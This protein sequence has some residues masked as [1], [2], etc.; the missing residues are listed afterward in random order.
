MPTFTAFICLIVV[1]LGVL[2]PNTYGASSPQ[3]H[4]N[5]PVIV[6]SIPP[7]A[8]ITRDLTGQHAHVSALIKGHASAHHF[9]LALSDQKMLQSADSVIW[10]G[11]T[12]EQFLVKSLAMR[13]NKQ[14]HTVSALSLIDTQAILD[15]QTLLD[16][17]K[18]HEH[19][20]KNSSAK[21]PKHTH[22]EHAAQNDPHIWTSPLLVAQLYKKLADE[23][24][25]RYPKLKQPI[26]HNLEVAL[27]TLQHTQNTIQQ[28]LNVAAK[29][30]H[31]YV[32]HDALTHFIHA[33]ELPK[34]QTLTLVPDESISAKQLGSLYQ[35]AKHAHCL[36]YDIN[37]ERQA[38][39]YGRKLK[40]K[41]VS[42][43]LLATQAYRS[44]SDYLLSL[45]R[46]VSVCF[47]DT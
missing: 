29:N 32:Y 44:Y 46:Q 20:A 15:T 28:R 19:T 22:A 37:E 33:F 47:A 38:L 40:L 25:Q 2:T 16:T 14:R 21:P 42:F 39:N 17:H 8:L 18:Q 13:K 12:L 34:P 1:F 7:L 23:L 6:T 3:T 10:I 31:F 43:D 35:H 26:M 24:S 36:M 41:T 9:S 27:A 11:P 5:I 30:K 45:S 4:K